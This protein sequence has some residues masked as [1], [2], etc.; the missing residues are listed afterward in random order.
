MV[1]TVVRNSGK[2][3][4]YTSPTT[5]TTIFKTTLN[6]FYCIMTLLTWHVFTYMLLTRRLSLGD[7]TMMMIIIIMTI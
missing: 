2:E 5:T 3:E 7:V 1:E 6:F 4:T